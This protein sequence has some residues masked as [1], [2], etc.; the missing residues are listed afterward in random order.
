LTAVLPTWGGERGD[1]PGIL[2]DGPPDVLVDVD[3]VPPVP[4]LDPKPQEVEC[5]RGGRERDEHADGRLLVVEDSEDAEQN[6]LD[7]GEVVQPVVEQPLLVQPVL[8]QPVDLVRVS[9]GLGF[10]EW[11]GHGGVTVGRR[12]NRDQDRVILSLIN[13]ASCQI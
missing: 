4:H 8:P 5:E 6:D 13:L 12:T 3:A 1:R 9:R 7:R 2:R 10:G 11:R